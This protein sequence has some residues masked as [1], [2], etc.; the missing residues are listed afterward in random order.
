MNHTEILQKLHL[1]QQHS[2][3]RGLS[4]RHNLEAWRHKGILACQQFMFEALASVQAA[5]T[6]KNELLQVTFQENE[7]P[8]PATLERAGVVK[9]EGLDCFSGLG[10]KFRCSQY[11][12]HE[13]THLGGINKNTQVYRGSRF[14]WYGEK[15][16]TWIAKRLA[17]SVWRGVISCQNE[18][19]FGRFF[20]CQIFKSQVLQVVTFLSPIVG[21]HWTFESVKVTSRIARTVLCFGG[22]KWWQSSNTFFDF[23]LGLFWQ[24]VKLGRTLQMLKRCWWKNSGYITSWN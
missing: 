15:C 5:K 14:C 19:S 3:E 2:K 17:T 13:I 21:G 18:Q 20:S 10:S 4:E 24:M 1:Q 8:S 6:V 11:R 22:F 7:R 12:D 23:F 9:T 16:R